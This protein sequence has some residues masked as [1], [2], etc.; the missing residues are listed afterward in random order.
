MRFPVAHRTAAC[1]VNAIGT[2]DAEA[3]AGQA[4]D[5]PIDCAAGPAVVNARNSCVFKHTTASHHQT[6]LDT[7][8]HTAPSTPRQAWPFGTSELRESARAAHHQHHRFRSPTI[9]EITA[10]PGRLLE[11]VERASKAPNFPPW[12]AL[13]QL[14]CFALL[15]LL[16]RSCIVFHFAANSGHKNEQHQTRSTQ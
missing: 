14:P 7:T 11:R 12:P 3:M 15:C 4:R 9:N 1:P 5:G 6:P 2:H 8:T 10:D 16:L 13:T